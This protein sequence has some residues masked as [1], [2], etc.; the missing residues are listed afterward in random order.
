MH[1]PT[2]AT[3]SGVDLPNPVGVAPATDTPGGA[4]T[5]RG[6]PEVEIERAN[7]QLL[8]SRVRAGTWVLAA[9]VA[10]FATGEF[11][12]NRHLL[13]PLYAL[14]VV[15]L[16]VALGVFWS[17]RVARLRESIET[18]AMLAVCAI[19][20]TTAA[21]AIVA[22]DF[23]TPPL[24]FI[25]LEMAVATLLP[26]G[27][28]RQLVTVAAASAAL[29]WNVY[30]VAGT[31]A[32][33]PSYH[34]VAVAVAFAASLYVAN[35][36][37]RYRSERQRAELELHQAKEAAEAASRAKSEFLANMSHEIRTPMNGIIGMTELTLDTDLTAE[38][39]EY[40]EMVRSSADALLAVINDVLDFSKVEAGKL[41]LESGEFHLR[42][43]VGE[44]MKTLALRASQKGLEMVCDVAPDVPDQLIGDPGRLRQILVNLIGNAIKFTDS[45]EIVVRV[46]TDL[47][48]DDEIRLSFSV[49][50]T[51]IGIPRQVQKHIFEAFSQADGS[52]TR[53]YGGTGLGLAISARLV[54]LMGGDLAVQSDPG[55]GST[56]RFDARFAVPP[57]QEASRPA[58]EAPDLRDLPVL[59]V[60]DNETNR[61]ILDAMLA[62]WQM[63]P[64]SVAG[65]HAALAELMRAA[66]A[67]S[68]YPL[69]LIDAQMPE[70]DGFTLAR[71]IKESPRLHGAMV[72]M[73][74]SA[75]QPGDRVRCRELGVASY[76]TKPIT[77]SE[78][79]NAILTVLTIAPRPREEA[80]A[81]KAA[82]ALAEASAAGARRL[83]ILLAEDHPVNQKLVSRL[84]QKHH[85]QVMIASNGREAL[86]LLEAGRFDMVLMDVRMPDMDGFAATAAIRARERATGIRVP[87]IAMTA[88]AMKGDE[89]RCLQ[90]GMDDYVSK[91]I[92]PAKLFAALERLAPQRPA[93]SE[94]LRSAA[95]A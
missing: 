12:M 19:C 18:I 80:V 81:T 95:G 86:S 55:L 82:P 77:Q 7:R 73:L 38:Q 43:A 66:A 22:G 27:P 44:T 11:W 28:W 61:R 29:L 74:S 65:G 90:A 37:R 72:M 2:S 67:G 54:A 88:H 48:S 5:S 32:V 41:E 94:P 36:F 40:L 57:P 35:E 21:G 9:G 56:F 53:R 84:L 64:S 23:T 78:L 15:E 75:A 1:N 49:I 20:F 39:R 89:E 83:R 6:V 59:V 76:V 87:I 47:R 26:W 4:G 63:R 46:R 79:L 33:V 31:L 24:L 62:N 42:D 92:D 69:I 58:V 10:I 3:D 34:G 68:P 60:D 50:D 85:H 71:R 52:T 8:V 70:M 13:V 14:K 17:L 16:S 51:G 30:A 91:P 25:V 93:E 45:G